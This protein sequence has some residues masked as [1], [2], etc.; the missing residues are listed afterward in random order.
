VNSQHKNKIVIL[1]GSVEAYL[2]AWV[3]SVQYAAEDFEISVIDFGDETGQ[4]GLVLQQESLSM[5]ARFK[6]SEKTLVDSTPLTYRLATGFEQWREDGQPVIQPLGAHGGP[7]ESIQFHHFAVKKRRAGS[8][9]DFN[10]YALGAGA[11]QAGKFLHPQSKPDS[12]FSTLGYGMHLEAA[13]FKAFLEQGCAERGVTSV[14]ASADSVTPVL[15]GGRIVRLELGDGDRVEVDWLLDCSNL[16][17][18]A[19][20]EALRVGFE[21]WEKYF[22]EDRLITAS[23]STGDDGAPMTRVTALEEGQIVQAP[24]GSATHASFHFCSA[25]LDDAAAVERLRSVVPGV[26]TVSRAQAFHAGIR[27]SAWIGNYVALGDAFGR[28]ATLDTSGFHAFLVAL[29]RF[30][31]LFPRTPDGRLEAFEFNRKTRLWYENARDLHLMRRVASRFSPID[32]DL[33]GALPDACAHKLDLFRSTGQLAYY[34][35]EPFSDA[36]RA[37]ALINMGFWPREHHVLLDRFDFER[38]DQR[39]EDL[40]RMIAETVPQMPNHLD[41]V[42]NVLARM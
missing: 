5:L 13:S 36:Y 39:F 26:E 7:I 28:F 10:D 33:D 6:I 17:S 25:V 30:L 12:I 15:E 37:S 38:L 31:N 4:A 11:A 34:E 27:E 18:N 20:A 21:R 29:D 32:G 8:E 41:Y 3:L 1:G 9:F 22:P 42:R 14:E 24:L 19:V 35:E 2:A 40:K 16:E 23:A